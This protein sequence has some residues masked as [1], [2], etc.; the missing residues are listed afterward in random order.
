MPQRLAWD[1]LNPQLGCEAES[2]PTFLGRD[3]LC[4]YSHPNN[5]GQFC[6]PDRRC[7]GTSDSVPEATRLIDERPRAQE[8][9]RE[10]VRI[11]DRSHSR[12]AEIH[13]STSVAVGLRTCFPHAAWIWFRTETRSPTC[14]LMSSRTSCSIERRFFRARVFRDLATLSGTFRIVRVAMTSPAST[15]LASLEPADKPLQPGRPGSP[16]GNGSAAPTPL[17]AKAFGVRHEHFVWRGVFTND[18]TID[19]RSDCDFRPSA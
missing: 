1:G 2:L 13:P 3:D 14:S 6:F 19:D 9:I 16:Q 18:R 15:M 11:N 17:N 4:P 8:E 5:V 12:P 10:D 7:H